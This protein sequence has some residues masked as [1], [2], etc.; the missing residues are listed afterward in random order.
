MRRAAR[1]K[2]LQTADLLG[3]PIAKALLGKAVLPDDH[4]Y[5]TGGVG[6]LGAR[7]SQQV[8][9]ECDTLLIVGSTFPYIEYYPKPGQ[10]RSV[11]IDIDAARI[12]LR[13][14][15]EA[16]IVGDAADSLRALNALLDRQVRPPLP[17]AGAGVE[18]R[19]VPAR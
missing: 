14:P 4:P 8:F 6:Y 15:V 1:L 18:G 13:F 5:V 2:L 19:M 12:G 17:R 16:G 11:Q 7:P 10:V 3:A 9:A